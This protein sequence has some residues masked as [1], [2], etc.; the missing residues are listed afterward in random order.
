[1]AQQLAEFSLVFDGDN[2]ERRLTLALD[3]VA[4]SFDA[5][6]GAVII[7]GAV[8]RSIGL[9]DG[10]S[11]A[12]STTELLDDVLGA[13]LGTFVID[14]T[15]VGSIHV[16]SV[17]LPRGAGDHRLIVGRVSAPLDAVE[18]T[19]L[20]SMARTLGIA[21]EL[22]EARALER[23][24]HDEIAERSQANSVLV[25]DL[26]QR[27]RV[28]DH[29]FRIQRSIT[30]RAPI[31]SVLDS[32]SVSAAEL[33]PGTFI[34]L[35]LV[36]AARETA[37]L[38]SIVGPDGEIHRTG[39]RIRVGEGIGGR[40]ISEN[41]FLI[42]DD[43]ATSRDV[44]EAYR[45]RGITTVMASPVRRNGEAVGT[46]LAVSGQQGR[47]FSEA[48]Q[49]LLQSLAEHGSLAF[50]DAS[51]IEVI[52]RSLER[53]VFDSQHDQ[54]T[55]LANRKQ[56]IERL[57]AWAA[58]DS[59]TTVIFVDLDRF[60][61]I[62]DAYGHSTGDEILRL[63]AKRLSDATRVDDLVARLSGDEF[64]VLARSPDEDTAIELAERIAEALTFSASVSNR[65][66]RVSASV[67][68]ARHIA[69][70][71]ADDVVAN[72]DL[73]MYRAKESGG[74]QLIRF[75]GDM[76]EQ[77]RAELT[78]EREIRYA[79]DHDELIVHF[80]PVIDLATSTLIG[81]EAL[82][83][84][85]H[86]VRGLLSPAHFVDAAE[87]A[88]LITHI[89]TAALRRSV[90]QLAT[91]DRAGLI[92]P[93]FRISVNVSAHQ[94]RDQQLVA[95]VASE[96]QRSGVDPSRL[97]LEITE[98]AMMRDVDVSLATMHALTELGAHLSVDDFGT[99]WSSLAYLKQFP[100]EA[101]K[102]D[103]SFVAG[104]C[105]SADDHAIVEATI[106]LAGALGLSVIAEGV[107]DIDQADEL[108]RLGCQSVQ[109]YLYSRPVPAEDFAEHWLMPALAAAGSQ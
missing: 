109:G 18:L 34:A 28:L 60:K 46:L 10:A 27:Q 84:W 75:D 98:T 87:V 108:H 20:R 5:E 93:K 72:A 3:R 85:N 1:M 29:L 13:P 57:E 76:R 26:S 94:F 59:G 102:I 95:S 52:Q 51:A 44:L 104:L 7:D 40:S 61:S 81:A 66:I 86:P 35:R 55:G 41:R 106:R 64:L 99:G 56:A 101:L 74:G 17:A 25:A 42:A 80:Q 36:E 22:H 54:L 21:L 11:S 15:A 89:D 62:N 14:D 2:D 50:N 107:E 91:W 105:T 37:A 65:E 68:C 6:I 39:E 79:I 33:I 67:G 48:E 90:E 38:V 8:R 4:E 49:H 19:L 92:G 83:R 77:R 31:M 78:L 43:Y 70:E 45:A 12:S 30:E 100:V 96:L 53:A 97:W 82:I 58:D 103:Q 71:S 32:I 23:Q 73:A 47:R 9:T 63:V 69:G 16:S 88:G 24:L